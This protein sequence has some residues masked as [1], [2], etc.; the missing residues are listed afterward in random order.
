M[1]GEGRVRPWWEG[2]GGGT[3]L[4]AGL[5]WAYQIFTVYIEMWRIL[6]TLLFSLIGTRILKLIAR[7]VPL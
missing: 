6:I 1:K 2:C 4:Q 7:I 3:R 5:D